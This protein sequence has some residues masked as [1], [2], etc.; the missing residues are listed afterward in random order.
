MRLRRRFIAE[1]RNP[2]HCS[3][4]LNITQTIA[5]ERRQRMEETRQKT[6]ILT[7]CSSSL[8]DAVTRP[9]RENNARYSTVSLK[10]QWRFMD[11]SRN[12]TEK[13]LPVPQNALVQ[14]ADEV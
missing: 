8:L 2:R 1:M 14:A 3:R 9:V 13:A 5:K 4:Y 12:T 11:D 7:A 6:Y 10:E